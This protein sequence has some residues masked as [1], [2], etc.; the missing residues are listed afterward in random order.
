M[1]R[2]VPIAPIVTHPIT[3]G[4]MRMRRTRIKMAAIIMFFAV[5]G[6]GGNGRF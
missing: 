2:Q 5:N 3:R 1:P 4:K 6:V